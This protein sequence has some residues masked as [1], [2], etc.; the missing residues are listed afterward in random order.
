MEWYYA[1]DRLLYRTS[2]RRL[3]LWLWWILSS[4]H[5]HWYTRHHFF[6]FYS[7]GTSSRRIQ[8]LWK[9]RKI[10]YYYFPK[11]FTEG[12]KIK[13][14][15]I[16]ALRETIFMPVQKPQILIPYIDCIVCSM[17]IAMLGSTYSQYF[18]SINAEQ[19]VVRTTF[20]LIGISNFVGKFI[21]G[22]FLDQTEDAPVIFSLV[23]N[24]LMLMPYITLGTLPYW[25]ISQ[26]SQQWVIFT[27]SPLLSCG[28]VFV[29]ISTFSRMYNVVASL[30][31]A[32]DT[33]ALI[34]GWWRCP[35]PR[36]K[37][38]VRIWFW[39]TGM[40]TSSSYLGMFLGPSIGGILIDNYGFQEAAFFF[41]CLFCVTLMIDFK[42]FLTHTRSRSKEGSGDSLKI[43]ML[44][45][46]ILLQI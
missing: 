3:V 19:F 5:G 41:S 25:P 6:N 8:K 42:E 30:V 29:Y 4:V 38:N 11:N 40:W 37:K 18:D 21:S 34:S 22:S 35:I 31:N 15:L 45:F 44:L 20:I 33:S 12:K 14:A 2:D 43:L 7:G 9:S 26:Y 16:A 27:T 32:V 1:G 23:G 17:G 28:F 24:S 10:L 39:T 13:K 46:Q 36:V